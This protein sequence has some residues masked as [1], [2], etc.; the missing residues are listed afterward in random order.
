MKSQA[1]V[2]EPPRIRTIAFGD[3]AWDEK[4]EAKVVGGAVPKML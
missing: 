3:K 1:I 4:I 2:I